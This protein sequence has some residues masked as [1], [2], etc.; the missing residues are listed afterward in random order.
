MKG[1]TTMKILRFSLLFLL[2]ACIT[3]SVD[4]QTNSYM[5]PETGLVFPETLVEMP[6]VSLTDHEKDNPGLGMSI[7]YNAPGI[8]VTV[9]LYTLGL[10]S[11]S[12]DL[13]SPILKEHFN[14]VM[15][16]IYKV[17]ELGYYKNVKKLAQGTTF[18]KQDNTGPKALFALLSYVQGGTDRLSKLYL[19]GH[20]NHF[21][22]IRFTYDK[23][24]QKHSEETLKQFL[25]EIGAMI[26]R[27]SQ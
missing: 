21:I 17:E 11:I 8:T 16:D 1:E 20:K 13:A 22:K 15:Q 23:A 25:N 7:G 18:L 6:M 26:Q 10:R 4:A 24:V 5:H 2:L 14:Q 27:N 9:Y 19:L 3:L 12:D